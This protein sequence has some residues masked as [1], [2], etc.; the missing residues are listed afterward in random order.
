MSPWSSFLLPFLIYQTPSVVE[1][2]AL[3]YQGVDAYQNG[4]F[5]R[6]LECWQSLVQIY[7]ASKYTLPSITGIGDVYFQLQKYRTAL[8]TYQ[9]AKGRAT[10][11][12][13]KAE[14]DLKIYECAYH[15]GKYP[16][17]EDALENF[18]S[19]HQD[20]TRTGGIVAPTMLRLA[21]IYVNQKEFYSA[22]AL[23]QRLLQTYPETPVINEATALLAQVNK[24]LGDVDAYKKTLQM[25]IDRKDTTQFYALALVDLANLYQEEQRY[26]S[27][28][29]CW[30]KLHAIEDF[31]DRA[32][33]EISAIYYRMGFRDEAILLL[34]TLLRDFPTSPFI[35]EAYELLLRIFK[36]Q[37]DYLQAKELLLD[38]L[39]RA[40]E[41]PE[42]LLELG[43]IGLELKDY[44]LA[45]DCYLRASQAFKERR[46][47][48]ARALLLAGDVAQIIGDTASARHYYQNAKMIA[49]SPE[50]K[51]CAAEKIMQIR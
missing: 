33:K 16:T 38:Q 13:L 29:A 47:D 45:L 27:A 35:D 49:L 43:E 12:K 31:Q 4:E 18:L 39:K 37:G 30:T 48:S 40:P 41:Q 2:S 15:L 46:D 14:L 11:E 51:N 28:L 5:N 3:F 34:Q 7:P 36:E 24:L 44:K 42:K 32:L 9:Q 8:R 50:I 26:D 19:E 21:R 25:I 6:A 22:R 17:L 1:D 23:L 20:T 10:D